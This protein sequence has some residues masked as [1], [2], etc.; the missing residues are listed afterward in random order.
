MTAGVE[1]ARA[2]L[3]VARVVEESLAGDDGPDEYAVEALVRVAGDELEASGRQ[4]FEAVEAEGDTDVA[5]VLIAAV[6][7]VS[8]GNTLIAAGQAVGETDTAA[9]AVGE[10]GV[11][12]A[13]LADV[14]DALDGLE[15]GAGR[16]QG[17]EAADAS[18]SVEAALDRVRDAAERV[19]DGIAA[20]AAGTVT[21]AFKQ[22]VKLVPEKIRD[23][24]DK[25]GDKVDLGQYAG[26][27]VKLGVRAV[28]RALD[29]FTRMFPGG[30]LA[31][32]RDDVKVLYAR[33]SGAEPIPATVGFVIG[34]DD[35]KAYLKLYGGDRIEQ[36]DKAAA[37][38]EQLGTKYANLGK[39]ATNLIEGIAVAGAV[40]ALLQLAVPQLGLIVAG[41]LAAVV[42][43]VL[44]LAMDY[45]G[46]RPVLHTIRG[47]KL[48]LADAVG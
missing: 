28:Q 12:V 20:T 42:A 18:E 24:A 19:A 40:V 10:Y 34:V 33:L 9:D 14:V 3:D 16:R 4:G 23:V 26:R 45:V 17:F 31:G 47:V 30:A 27:L 29:L 36:L 15:A 11:A 39:L 8:A 35:V 38:V 46:D 7:Q 25:I 37:D 44:L 5:A 48:V 22:T 6:V 21:E 41:A 13:R 2:V 1:S 32:M 43:G